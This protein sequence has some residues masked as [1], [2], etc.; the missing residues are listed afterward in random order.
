MLT[1]RRKYPC[2]NQQMRCPSGISTF[3]GLAFLGLSA[4]LFLEAPASASQGFSGAFAPS[5][6][7]T[8]TEGDSS[9][10]TTG[11]PPS[12]SLTSADDDSGLIQNADFTIPAPSAGQVIFDWAFSTTDSGSIGGD[13]PPA[14]DPFGYLL[15]GQ[16][17]QLTDDVGAVNQS[18]SISFPVTAGDT[19]GF[20]QNSE[21]SQFGSATT[22]VSN[23]HFLA[24]S[25]AVPGPLP[26]LGAAAAFGFSRRLRKRIAR[27]NALPV[28]SAID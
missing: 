7:T 6:W 12:I 26:A 24:E 19:F 4:P 23:F 5:N 14:F 21:D 10:D 3:V 16:F 20:R 11:A 1:Y 9:I 13:P 8:V 25:A 17:F 28:A 15:N 22:I 2:L 18:G 27:R